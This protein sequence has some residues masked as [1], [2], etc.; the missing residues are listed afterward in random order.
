MFEEAFGGASGR[1]SQVEV[2]GTS[3]SEARPERWKWN[4]PGLGMP[5]FDRSAQ[6]LERLSGTQ[7]RGAKLLQCLARVKA[8]L[9]NA[10][11]PRQSILEVQMPPP[12]GGRVGESSLRG[13]A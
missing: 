7:G 2:R 9:L 11:T 8:L 3:G 13:Q 4:D 12:L 5:T 6:K 1:P 10:G